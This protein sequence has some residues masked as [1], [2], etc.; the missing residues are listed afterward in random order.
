MFNK[1][2]SK[3]NTKGIINLKKYSHYLANKNKKT[4]IKLMMS[5]TA[6]DKLPKDFFQETLKGKAEMIKKYYKRHWK[7][8]SV[9]CSHWAKYGHI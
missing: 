6:E 4:N 8:I 1:A 2:A 7:S 3:L 5:Y 9:Y